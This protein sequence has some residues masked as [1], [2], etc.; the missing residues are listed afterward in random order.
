MRW[1]FQ[2]AQG[3]LPKF[4]ETQ[5]TEVSDTPK[6]PPKF[7]DA[8]KSEVSNT[9]KMPS[10]FHDAQK[11]EVSDTQKIALRSFANSSNPQID[12]LQFPNPQK[13]LP[14]SPKVTKRPP[15]FPYT[16][17]SR[18]FLAPLMRPHPRPTPDPP[19]KKLPISP[20]GGKI[21]CVSENRLLPLAEVI[22]HR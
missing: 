1:E 3:R 20:S 22:R 16:P 21:G 15:K 6:S 7:R 4:R 9:L 11:S 12:T 17:Q 18:G 8:Q 5:K 10:E 14:K 19:P 2:R 13:C